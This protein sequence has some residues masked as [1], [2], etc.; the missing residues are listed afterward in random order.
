MKISIITVSYNAGSTIGDT[1]ASVKAQTWDEYEHIIIDGASTDG[2]AR[3]LAEHAGARTIIVSEPDGGI[4]DAMNKGARLASGDLIGFLNADDFYTRVNSLA[5]LADAALRNPRAAAVGGAVALVHPVHTQRI[6]RYYR[7]AGFR[8]WMLQYG[9]MPPH[10]GFYVRRD[11]MRQVGEFDLAIRTGGDFEWM[12]RFFHV[13]KLA[14][15]ALSETLVGFRLGG[16]SSSGFQSL[17]NINREALASCRRWGLPSSTH[18][19][20]AKYLVKSAQFLDRPS[21]FPLAPPMGWAP[22]CGAG[23]CRAS[24]ATVGDLH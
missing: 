3:L 9:H 12:V 8:P 20:W 15:A 22:R 18:A 24:Q 2:T 19:V 17:R 10:P 16:N 5:L 1:L 23:D 4:F 21:D 6:R 7:S 11:A 13:H 14:L